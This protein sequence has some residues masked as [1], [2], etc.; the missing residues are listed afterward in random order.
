MPSLEIVCVDQEEPLRFAPFEWAFALEAERG[1]VSHRS[2]RPLF[3][4]DFDTLNGCLYHLGSPRLRDPEASGAYT[5]FELL[6]WI[7]ATFEEGAL[8][9]RPEFAAPA[10]DLLGRL[11]RTSPVGRAVW[12]SDYQFGPPEVLRFTPPLSLARFQQM[13]DVGEVRLNAL[14][15]LDARL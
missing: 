11:L 10:F 2:P 14:Y 6:H 5:A 3:Q 13:H 7:D 15:I 9:L 12:T 8:I 4:P 1:L